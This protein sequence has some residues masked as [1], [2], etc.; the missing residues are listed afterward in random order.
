MQLIPWET[1]DI[2]GFE[3]AKY[4]LSM[5][6]QSSILLGAIALL[7]YGLRQR[8]ALIRYRLWVAAVL[9]TP[10]L[11]LLSW[12]ASQVGTPQVPVPLIPAYT[13]EG[14]LV[15][16][17]PA[18][19]TVDQAEAGKPKPA[20]PAVSGAV[21]VGDTG[22]VPSTATPSPQP[23]TVP[24]AAHP[25][26]GLLIVYLCGLGV[27][28]SLILAGLMRIAKYIRQGRI[29]TEPGITRLFDA[30]RRKLG[31]TRGCVVVETDAIQVPMTIR[32]FYPVVALPRDFTDTL[33]HSEWP[34]VALHEVAHIQ[35]NDPLLLSVVSVLRAILFFHPLVWLAAREI[36]TL[37]EEATDDMVLAADSTP[38]PY[39]KMLSRLT[40][41]LISRHPLAELAVGVVFS[42]SVL[43]RR[44]EAILSD[45]SAQLRRLSRW[46][47]LTVFAV[48]F[49]SLC[50]AIAVPLTSPLSETGLRHTAGMA[51]SH[52][53]GLPPLATPAAV[54]SDG[55]YATYAESSFEY[56]IGG[57][58]TVT[59]HDWGSAE[60]ALFATRLMGNLAI[61]DL[62][63]G[64]DWQITGNASVETRD[65]YNEHSVFSPDDRQIAY[66]WYNDHTVEG[67]RFSDLRIIDRDGGNMR[68]LFRGLAATPLL[69]PDDWSP[70]GRSVL[71]YVLSRGLQREGQQT[72][73]PY[74]EP[75]L[76]LFTVGDGSWEALKTFPIG[77]WVQKSAF[78]PD[79]R[80][81]AYD[82]GRPYD[83]HVIEV[84]TGTE[85]PL[86]EHPAQDRLLG[87][88]P[89]GQRVVFSSDRAPELSIW[90]IDVDQGI[91]QGPPRLLL[92][93]SRRSFPIRVTSD[94]SY[95]YGLSANTSN[96]YLAKLDETGLGFEEQPKLVSSRHVGT[97]GMGDF[98]AD[99]KFLAYKAGRALGAHTK[100]PGDWML[101]VYSL[102]TEE[103]H[104]IALSSP[105]RP[106]TS[107]SGPQWSPDGQSLFVYGSVENAGRG[108]HRVEV[109]T[110][111]VEVM[112]L[113]AT[114]YYAPVVWAPDG[115]VG[116]RL[117]WGLS[118]G[119]IGEKARLI[120]TGPWN[121][122]DFDVSPDGKWVAFYPTP[123]SLAVMPWGDGEPREVVALDRYAD[124][125]PI[126]SWM[127]DSEH[128]LFSK[129]KDEL[130]RV[131]VETGEEQQIGPPI[132][133]LVQVTMHPDG[134]QIAFTVERRD[135]DLWVME[136]FLPD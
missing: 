66:S 13:G 124:V 72:R 21:G 132:E 103:N 110:G 108:V 43:L 7:T 101:V 120:Y 71:A 50:L 86:I 56:G 37:S 133:N 54:S 73:N 90:A 118:K 53:W 134:R 47:L 125:Y 27:F 83:I 128:L 11:P 42:K 131:N 36:Y 79:G 106:D 28:S 68:V 93:M 5:L 95:Y 82:V 4:V 65:G 16:S 14:I 96:L 117:A 15:R 12:T 70:D 122:L 60:A 67:P 111:T 80:Y 69:R 136:N 19:P 22:A 89:D 64:T 112:G 109:G 52:L 29:V 23:E 91:A 98:S 130:W 78:S 34:T 116:A 113:I 45:R 17:R 9:V 49:G 102:D 100:G 25:W 104:I 48:V 97:T 55:R 59:P 35:R 115:Y 2:V 6:W 33:S 121:P 8:K 18:E 58:R 51:Q 26:A 126:V 81:V 10:V 75:R 41:T 32:T 1:L 24:D 135:M 57:I 84:D 87:W 99:G 127:P 85:W 40:E 63:T 77:K 20:S 38:L 46:G 30:A 44:I 114:T 119:E 92:E 62:V 88:A 129:R 61:R 105:F 39:A 76:V 74:T 3:T 123:Y 94:G 107:M 31:H